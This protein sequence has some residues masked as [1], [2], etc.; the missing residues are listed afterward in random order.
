MYCHARALTV[1]EGQ[2]VAVGQ[3]IGL[4]GSTGNSTGNHLH[5]QIHLDSPPVDASTTTDPRLSGFCRRTGVRNVNL[6]GSQMAHSQKRCR[7]SVP[8]DISMRSY[9]SVVSGPSEVGSFSPICVV[10]SADSRAAWRLWSLA[11]SGPVNY[12]SVA[13]ASLIGSV[14]DWT[15]SE[16][17]SGPRI[18]SAVFSENRAVSVSLHMSSC[19]SRARTDDRSSGHRATMQHV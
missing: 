18:Q 4:V 19:T 17:W 16:R 5:F 8:W 3:V 14:M 15:A 10:V 2:T 12:V 11:Y 13:L 7:G 1:H 9:C 6:V